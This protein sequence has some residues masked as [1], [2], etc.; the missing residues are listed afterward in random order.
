MRRLDTLRFSISF[1]EHDERLARTLLARAASNDSFPGLPQPRDRADILLAP[2]AATFRAWIGPSVPEWGVAIAVPEEHTIVMQGSRAGARDGDPAVTLRHE[3]AHLALRETMGDLPPRWF[4]EGYAAYAAGEWGRDEV[5]ATNVA[6]VLR[7]VPALD[8]LDALFAA[9][10]A[11]ATRGYAL[12]HR[13][14]A[15][16]A[17]LD[18]ERGLSLFFS[19]WRETKSFEQ[20][21]RRAFGMTSSAFE[22]RWQKVTRRRYGAL[23]LV[24]DLSIASVLMLIFVGPLWIS[25]MSRDRRRMADMRAA[26]A[27]QELRDRDSAIAALLGE[28]PPS[29]EDFIK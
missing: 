5:L 14:V 28:A 13:A 27:A 7:G 12:A 4:D 9:G 26:E 8:E 18:R 2:D 3:L 11:R 22:E 10:E 16:L 29:N 1:V 6:L 24:A 15:E 25:R 21:V 23:A 19:Y 20:A 17:G